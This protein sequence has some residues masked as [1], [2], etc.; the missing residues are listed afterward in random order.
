MIKY[1]MIG[2]TMS[3]IENRI[4]E[5]ADITEAGLSLFMKNNDIELQKNKIGNTDIDLIHTK[6][7]TMFDVKDRI[8]KMYNGEA[9]YAVE[10]ES[11]NRYNDICNSY[12]KVHNFTC[13]LA[14]PKINYT[15]QDYG[16]QFLNKYDHYDDEYYYYSLKKLKNVNLIKQYLENK[17]IKLGYFRNYKE[18]KHFDFLKKIIN[19]YGYQIE[20]SEFKI[21]EKKYKYIQ[22]KDTVIFLHNQSKTAENSKFKARLNI[23]NCLCIGKSKYNDILLFKQENID[24]KV[25]IVFYT[26]DDKN[27]LLKEFI[28]CSLNE[29][30]INLNKEI[31]S[32]Y[33]RNVK[34]RDLMN[35][36]KDDYLKEYEFFNKIEVKK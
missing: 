21:N 3:N 35:L 7:N 28:F 9:Y 8:K 27:K 10:I 5:H 23:D 4:N 22:L 25:Y 13:I 15:N 12:A 31:P 26:N 30:N 1:V 16:F 33:F 6:S 24:K 36:C 18:G 11:I 2:D 32:V 14:F 19:E 17:Y 34:G 20:E 29:I